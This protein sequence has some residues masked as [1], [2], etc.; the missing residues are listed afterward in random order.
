MHTFQNILVVI[1]CTA[2]NHPVLDAAIQLAETNKAS[3]QIVD[4]VPEF[5]WP[6][7]LLVAGSGHIQELL[8]RE[9]SQF[10]KNLTARLR[11]RGLSVGSKVLVGSSSVEVIRQVMR[12]K[13]DLV[14]KDAKGSRSRR[15]GFFGTTA[16][17]LLRKCPCAVWLF[18]PGHEGKF[19]RVLAAVD[20]DPDEPEQL[21]LSQRILECAKGLA[22][23][24]GAHL[25]VL[26]VWSIYGEKVVRDYMKTSDFAELETGLLEEH[27]RSLQKLVNGCGLAMTEQNV[28]LVRGEPAIEIPAFVR[29]QQTDLLVMGT[30]GRRG[31][32]GLMMGNTAEMVLNQVQCSILALKPANFVSPVKVRPRK[33][34]AETAPAA[35]LVPMPPG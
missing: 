26:H 4:V 7:R 33:K 5:S 32:A 23:Q 21:P 17:E 28:H 9:K 11:R 22:A 1:D 8:V 27:T 25:D 2:E 13:H 16:L 12:A 6:Q 24:H 14:L 19:D 29:E 3:L 34:A 20:V 35:V 10:L 15:L 31:L 18:K 30:V